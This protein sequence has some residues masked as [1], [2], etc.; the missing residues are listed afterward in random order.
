MGT[1][2]LITNIDGLL[3]QTDSLL[4]RLFSMDGPT[5]RKEIE[6]LKSKGHKYIPSE[7]CKHFDPVIGCL[8]EFYDEEGKLINEKGLQEKTGNK[9]FTPLR[10]APKQIDK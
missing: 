6:E 2:H 9:D 8:C 7:N 5:A 3:K 4:S 10:S 1:F